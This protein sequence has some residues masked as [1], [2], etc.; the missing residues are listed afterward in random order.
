MWR[1][2][3]KVDAGREDE[4]ERGHEDEIEDRH[5][6]KRADKKANE[7]LVPKRPRIKHDKLSN[8]SDAS[9]HQNVY[10]EHSLLQP[11]QHT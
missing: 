2:K 6:E 5:G 11:L 8:S 3:V 1:L 10:E 4:D 7:H 9:Q